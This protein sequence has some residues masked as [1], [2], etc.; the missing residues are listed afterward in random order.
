MTLTLIKCGTY[1]N[2][3]A[4][5]GGHNFT[6]SIYPH[7][8]NFKKGGTINE[9]YLLNR[10][11]ETVITSGEGLLPAEYSFVSCDMDNIIIET[12]KKA[13]DGKGIIMRFYDAWDKKSEPTFNFGFDSKRIY[14]CD[15][16]ENKIEDIGRGNTVKLAVKNFEIVTLYIEI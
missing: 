5:Q 13:E 4:D 3:D 6:Y 10:P 11:L 14:V 15:M 16:L 8:G 9:A 12:I 7:S 2:P 1:P